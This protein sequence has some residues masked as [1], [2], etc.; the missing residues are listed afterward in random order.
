MVREAKVMANCLPGGTSFMEQ[1]HSSSGLGGDSSLG[2]SHVGSLSVKHC[3][4][5]TSKTLPK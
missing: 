1:L 4:Q 2:F 5:N 3:E